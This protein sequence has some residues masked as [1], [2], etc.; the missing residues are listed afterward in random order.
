MEVKLGGD[1][2]RSCDFLK[3][4]KP[5]NSCPWL[6]CGD[7]NEITCQDE[8]MGGPPRPYKQMEIFRNAL[9]WCSLNQVMTV[10]PKY[11]WANNTRDQNFTKELLDRALAN[12]LWLPLFK[13]A[14]CSVTPAVKSDRS[15]LH[16]S[17]GDQRY[18]NKIF[19]KPF[20]F[21]A[22][23]SI[24]KGCATIIKEVWGKVVP[25]V[26]NTS[27]VTK[28]LSNY[29]IALRRWNKTENRSSPIE[30]KEKMKRLS[31]LQEKDR[32]DQ[33]GDKNTKF[34][35]LHATQRRKTNRI[36]QIIDE[37]ELPVNEKK[38]IGSIFSNFFQDL[39]TTS[40]PSG[41]VEC[42]EDMPMPQKVTREMNEYLEKEYT[43]EEIKVAVFQMNGLGFLGLDEV[44]NFAL[45]IL[46]KGGPLEGVNDTYIALIPKI[47]E[48]K[49]VTDFRPKTKVISN[50][51]KIVLP[52]IISPSQ[53]AFVP[54]RTITDNI[55]VAYELD[56]PGNKMHLLRDP[57]SPYLFI[58]CAKALSWLLYKAEKKRSV[59]SVP[60]G[61]GPTRVNH[62]FFDDDSLI[63]CKYECASGQVLNKEKSSIY[64]SKNTPDENK[65]TILYLGLPAMKTN[66]LSVAG[67]EVL[68][69]SVLQAIPTY[70]MGIF[71]L[72]KS[73]TDRLDKLL[74]KFWWGFNEDHTKIQ[75]VK[76]DRLSKPK[77]QGGQ[78]FRNF[79]SFNLALLAKQ[80]WPVLT[81]PHS[82]P[83]QILKQ[84]YFASGE[85]LDEK[86]GLRPSLA[87]RS[88]KVGMSLLK[89]GL[90][91]RI[92]NGLKVRI[93][94]DRWLPRPHFLI[95]C[96]DSNAEPGIA[97]VSDLVDHEFR[98][99]DGNLLNKLFPQE[100][101]DII[102]S[103]PISLGNREDRLG[104]GGTPNGKFTVK[105][106]YHL[107]KEL[108]TNLEGAT[109]CKSSQEG[110]WKTM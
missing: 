63:F 29:S 107:Y 35:H 40:N 32:G 41:I 33:V 1:V 53:S 67:K 83:A 50:R 18:Q 95:P 47:K 86:L 58:L 110:S 80:G 38:H 56:R 57:L 34:Y 7:F 2:H 106:A 24:K 68:I 45:N 59:S 25:G 74:R 82:L 70:T 11:T 49:K 42:L 76:W 48:S 20:R 61:K 12:P 101:V 26:N 44:N 10:G 88:L 31:E 21:E 85:F 100:V 15:P 90:Q 104:W 9:D 89:E 73:I 13:E 103:I 91:W 64:F 52:N 98:R 43:K 105:S 46:N 96:Q 14:S 62:L 5:V 99:W 36:S 16:I 17:L 60:M 37:R 51:L 69:K 55:V 28:K 4:L 79:R 66:C 92:D 22:A 30:I 94:E 39:F 84:K 78:G 77:D 108:Q 75:W 87:W 81:R 109:S 54:G 8:K 72:P 102:R 71:V 3:S 23:W 97:Q 19:S 65:R 6:C 93:W 27:V